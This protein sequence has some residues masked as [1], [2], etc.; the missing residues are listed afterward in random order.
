M[1]FYFK[2]THEPVYGA[3]NLDYE[4]AVLFFG[5]DELMQIITGLH[6][7]YFKK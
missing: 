7:I 3:Q 2:E 4:E 1:N 6:P 5:E